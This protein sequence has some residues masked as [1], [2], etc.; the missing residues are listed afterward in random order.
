MVKRNIHKFPSILIF[1]LLNWPQLF[2]SSFGT[3]PQA[4]VLLMSLCCGH[5][6]PAAEVMGMGSGQCPGGGKVE[7][8]PVWAPILTGGWRLSCVAVE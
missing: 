5:W 3:F 4:L 6:C 1:S 7:V 8:G 2:P